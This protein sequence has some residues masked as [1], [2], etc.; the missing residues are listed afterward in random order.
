VDL[1]SY[2]TDLR[3]IW[4]EVVL[5]VTALLALVSDLLLK[6]RDVRV[7]G[8]V[9]VLGVLFTIGLLCGDFGN[10]HGETAFGMM[11]HDRFALFFKLLIA[12]GLLV[13]TLLSMFFRGFQKDGVGEYYSL[14]V[15]AA[16]GSFFLVSTN[17]LLL[18]FLGLETLSISS[19][20]LAGFLKKD[21]RSSEAAVKYLVFGVLS[22]GA[23][24]YG[25]S[26]L[27][28]FAGS[29]DLT[30]IGSTIRT[31]LEAKGEGGHGLS[32][33]GIG[34]AIAV[35][36]SI[37]GFAYKVAAFPFHFWS[38]DVYEGAPTP[39]TT[40][41]S[42]VSK[43]ASFGMI[44]RFFAGVAHDGGSATIA[45]VVALLAACS[46]TFGNLAAMLQD[47]S[48]RLLAY[49]SIAHSGYMLAGVA[50]LLAPATSLS[51]STPV[52]GGAV[53]FA[54]GLT[55]GQAVAFYVA[56]Y[57]IMNLGAFASVVCLANRFG[58]ESIRGWTGLGWKAPVASGAFVMFLLSLTGLPPT[59]GFVGKWALLQPIWAKGL[60]WLAVVLVLNSIVS[61]F[62]YFRIAKSLL[63]KD[64]ST[65]MA[66]P[67]KGAF[68]VE[69]ATVLVALAIGTVWFGV[70]GG[71]QWLS[72]L[73]LSIPV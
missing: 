42:V 17:H 50:A 20:A 43:A 72:E 53:A 60:H 49:S 69:L 55:G 9:T 14:L 2:L 62:Y 40:F 6:G 7:T 10:A 67:R 35:V 34:V 8:W 45:S 23:M 57:A 16:V 64:E 71:F 39:V 11:V 31:L 28:G 4:P 30:K 38:P 37:A 27:Y 65:A 56:A 52:V 44:L 58:T 25:F 59:V 12:V 3:S 68:Q 15:T 33:A 24:V 26:L 47:N 1:Q 22:T 5:S 48:K 66:S 51:S 54:Y 29:L 19:Y 18:L 36:L 46:M 70:A 32:P 63:L 13:V 61:L 21:V 73:V 41:L